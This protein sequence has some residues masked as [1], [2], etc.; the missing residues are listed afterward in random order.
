ME[1]TKVVKP[2]IRKG[3]P[4]TFG[5][6]V[7]IKWKIYVLGYFNINMYT[8]VE[9]IQIYEWR[10]NSNYVLNCTEYSVRALL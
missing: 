2:F 1:I 7:Y 8:Y 6:I 5:N 10:A 3:W 9:Y 4:N